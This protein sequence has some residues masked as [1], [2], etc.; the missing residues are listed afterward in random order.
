MYKHVEECH[1]GDQSIEF[2]MRRECVNQD[3]V[4]R[5]VMEALRIEKAMR[6]PSIVVLNSREEHYGTQ[7]VRSRFGIE[8][9]MNYFDMSSRCK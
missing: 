8:W 3:P 7:V 5:V 1:R 6:D 4:R 2:V 9:I